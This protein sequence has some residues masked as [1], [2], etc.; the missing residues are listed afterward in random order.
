MIPEAIPHSATFQ[1]SLNSS[2]KKN[3]IAPR[4]VA[5]AVISPAMNTNARFTRRPIRKLL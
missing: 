5:N 2:T 1:R 3:G 4:P